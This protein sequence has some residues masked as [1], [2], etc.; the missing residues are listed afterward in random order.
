MIRLKPAAKE[1]SRFRPRPRHRRERHQLAAAA[2]LMF[3]LSLILA[4]APYPQGSIQPW[5]W[6]LL[7]TSS[8]LLLLVTVILAAFGR[9]DVRVPRAAWPAL[10][11]AGAVV[12]WVALQS[13]NGIPA[14]MWHPIWHV[15]A[16]R[17]FEGM[18]AI[19]LDPATTS[20]ALLRLLTPLAIFAVALFTA[21]DESI[22]NHLTLVFTGIATAYAVYGV[23]TYPFHKGINAASAT[24][25]FANYNH[26]ATYVNLAIVIALSRLVEPLLERKR[27]IGQLLVK[28][29]FEKNGILLAPLA[30]LLV[31]SLLTGSR[32]GLVSLVAAIVFL[33]CVV[34]IKGRF[35]YLRTGVAVIVVTV[36][37]AGLLQLAGDRTVA[38]LANSSLEL[39]NPSG[40][41]GAWDVTL[42]MIRDRPWLGHGYGTFK[43][44]FELYGDD[45]FPKNYHHAHNTYLED[46]AGLG[47]PATAA[48]YASILCLTALC[49]QAL[50]RRR[51]H[52]AYP[53]A[54]ATATVLVGVHALFDFSIQIPA[55]A[56]SYAAILGVGCAQVERRF[57]VSPPPLQNSGGSVSK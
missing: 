7:A 16:T 57:G 55:V 53:L 24:S 17:G 42:D 28:E 34:A 44:A 51:R 29:V 26:F 19:S 39:E 11:L 38:R 27:S 31:A 30:M 12:A 47:L 18:P 36:M 33:F 52:R 4:W 54:A 25:T 6:A 23:A 49:M 46:A 48:W 3:G 2:A 45:R 9:L 21:R 37:G 43:A 8:A 15:L 1:D 40:R 32:G 20:D 13:I 10:L 5:S 41:I 56:V 14:S 35:D 50:T 22:A